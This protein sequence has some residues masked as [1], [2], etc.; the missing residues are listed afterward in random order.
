MESAAESE[1]KSIGDD[2]LADLKDEKIDASS[3]Q[4][5][6]RVLSTQEVASDED[7]SHETQKTS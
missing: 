6:N 2:G 1:G 5:P 7:S 4:E 3:M